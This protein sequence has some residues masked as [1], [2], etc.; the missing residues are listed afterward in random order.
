MQPYHTIT[1]QHRVHIEAC[2]AHFIVGAILDG[3]QRRHTSALRVALGNPAVA[4]KHRAVG[5][6]LGG[7]QIQ[8]RR[9]AS[10]VVTRVTLDTR[11]GRWN[12]GSYAVRL[13]NE[14][15]ASSDDI[16]CDRKKTYRQRMRMWPIWRP[17]CKQ[18]SLQ[19]GRS[20]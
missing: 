15:G 2:V 20:T 8:R 9:S 16:D 17:M 4:A 1:S 6:A 10:G 12:C 14:F 18:S 7:R 3:R 11:I 19:N 13:C 5:N